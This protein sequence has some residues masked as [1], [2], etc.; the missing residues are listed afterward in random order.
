MINCFKAN[1]INV[2]PVVMNKYTRSNEIAEY[3]FSGMI[4]IRKEGK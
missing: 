3:P 1:I 2:V 4:S